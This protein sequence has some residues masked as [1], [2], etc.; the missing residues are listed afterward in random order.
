M[1]KLEIQA[2]GQK[3]AKLEA[4]KQGITVIW[5]ITPNWL[6]AGRP[7]LTEDLKIFVAELLDS[8]DFFN[9]EGAGVIITT[10]SGQD[11]NRKCPYKTNNIKRKGR[12]KTKRCVQIRLKRNDEL[13]GEESTK[14]KALSKAKDLMSQYREDIYAHTVYK[15][16][17]CDFELTYTPSK[18]AKIGKYIIFGVDA[19]D[20][21]INKRK[22]RLDL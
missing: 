7:T 2:Y 17:D 4:F 1:K 3:A 13:I 18:G 11:D 16:Q 10:E 6:K 9:Y 22:N 12:C 14:L 8:R 15:G 19:E 20:V 5:D 21:R